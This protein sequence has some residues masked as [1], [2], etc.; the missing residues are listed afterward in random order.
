MKFDKIISLEKCWH[1][2]EQIVP[3]IKFDNSGLDWTVEKRQLFIPCGDDHCPVDGWQAVVRADNHLVLNIPKT[4]YSIIQNS[5]VWEIIENA[6]VGVNHKVAVTGSLQNCRKVF[7]SVSIDGK[8]DYVV[9]GDKFQ[10]F[11]TFTTSHDGSIALECYD[12]SIRV[13]CQNTLNA[14]RANK[15]GNVN[16]KV[17][18]TKGNEFKI[19][20]MEK[21]LEDLFVKRE[22][23]YNSLEYL[24]N[25]PMTVEQANKI[26]TG[27]LGSEEL[28]T[29]VENQVEEIVGLFRNGKGNQG[30]SAY[31]LL[32]GVTEYFTHNASDNKV[33][34]L[35]SNEFGSAGEKKVEFYD[36]LL[37]DKELDAL[38]KRG[39]KLL[40][41]ATTVEAVTV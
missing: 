4:T 26:L 6:L 18:H 8:Q 34:L 28:S 32:N 7:I 14:S 21:T 31:D 2:L 36:L 23:F 37:S 1:G 33:K 29:R 5:R 9:N 3:E 22:E 39:E 24:A 38:A 19:K 20:D 25:K 15:A 35:T 12:T 13:V 40:A 16:L 27:F 10:N 30:K 17:Y 41:Q 11:L